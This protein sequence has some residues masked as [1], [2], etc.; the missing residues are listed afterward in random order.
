MARLDLNLLTALDALL[1]EASVAAAARVQDIPLH[2][3]QHVAT[4]GFG[5][6]LRL[7]VVR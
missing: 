6:L 4:G 2:H 7:F 3:R 5:K 1:A